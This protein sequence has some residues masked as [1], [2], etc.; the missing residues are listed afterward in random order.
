MAA[1]VVRSQ[2]CA[3]MPRSMLALLH[4]SRNDPHGTQPHVTHDTYLLE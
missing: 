1:L 3:P 4:M 2:K